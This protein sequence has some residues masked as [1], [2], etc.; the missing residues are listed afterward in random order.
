MN[1]CHRSLTRGVVVGTRITA[2]KNGLHRGDNRFSR[3][4]RN[5]GS[6]DD[7]RMFYAQPPVAWT[8][9]TGR[10]GVSIQYHVHG[11]VSLRMSHE[12]VAAPIQLDHESLEFFGFVNQRRNQSGTAIRKEFDQV[13]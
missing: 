3:K 9:D 4:A 7:G 11:I 10:L 8:I 12:L 13:R 5:I 1:E 6:V 2:T